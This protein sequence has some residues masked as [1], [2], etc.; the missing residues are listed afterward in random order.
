MKKKTLCIISTLVVIVAMCLGGCGDKDLAVSS[1][2]SMAGDVQKYVDA[3]DMEYAYDLAE[4]LSY[5]EE[6][7]DNEL[8]WRT[9]GSDAEHRCAD[10]LTAEMEEIG[11]TDIE[12][13]GVTVDKFQFNDSSFTIDG[14][15]IDLMPAAY[16]CSGTDADGITAEIVNCGDGTEAAYDGKD[17]SGK[18]VLIRVDQANVGWIDSYIR[19]AYEK[20]AAAVV[21]YASSGYGE[22][23][24][25]TINVQDICC[26]DLI[27]TVAIS[28]NQ[29]KK[30]KK[31][32]KNG[33]NQA[34][35]MVDVVFEKGGGTSYNVVGKIKGKSSDQQIMITGHYDKYWYGFQDD[36]AAIALDFTV[37]KAMID[38]GYTPEN[39][40]V[41]VAHGSEEWGASDSQFDWTTGAWEM[42]DKV[43]PEWSSK[44]IA[45]L[46]CELPAFEV[47][48]MK[49]VSVPEF[50]TLV[51][52][53]V[54]ESGLVVAAEGTTLDAKSVDA[55][56]MED[57]VSYRW[58]GTPYFINGFEGTSFM[59]ERYHTIFDDK[60][61]WNE[62]T[63]Q[64][65]LNWYGAFAIYIDKTPALEMD[66]TCTCDDLEANLAPKIAKK[67]G[68]DVDAYKAEIKKM[69]KAAK[70]LNAQIDKVNTAY[71]E[72]V[73]GEASDEEIAKLREEGKAL[74]QKSLATFKEVQNQ[75]LKADDCG[76][77]IGHPTL[78]TNAKIL[79]QTIAALDKEV[80]WGDDGD[81]AL[82][83]IGNLNAYHD[84][85]Y[86]S[87]SKKVG[88]DINVQYD[89]DKVSRDLTFWATDKLV[90]VTY[91]GDMS[92]ELYHAEES[93]VDFEAAKSVYQTALD[94]LYGHIKVY[95]DQEV[96]G[97]HTLAEMMK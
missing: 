90:P 56:N 43:H 16:Q 8:G 85:A 52:K 53:L 74:N 60:D 18:I 24:K 64:T 21:S 73:A 87:F 80:L 33:S 63:M 3:L 51:N 69:R 83:I 40:I 36:S 39:D 92:Y 91:V 26:D 22:L 94:E 76:V 58:H 47:E 67:A 12:K 71:E 10:F 29:A 93:D 6:Y 57:G 65:N 77:Y 11:L 97:M 42:I 20:G 46:N 38:A 19:M 59:A 31:A 7:W 82:D 44:T 34:T 23:N 35:L 15:K 54:G 14:T 13:V 84:W 9:A 1:D 61:T 5:D 55:T 17:V 41:V 75:Y 32:I 62:A 95:C 28:A 68:V 86:Y 72:A 78:N 30:I 49:V 27:P 89:A 66:M 79:K 88:D 70:H 37:A 4:T 2:L 81:G 48:D 25:D 45:L 50:R 96:A